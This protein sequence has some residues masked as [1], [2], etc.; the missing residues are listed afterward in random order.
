[1][2]DL[3][4]KTIKSLDLLSDSTGNKENNTR[5]KEM[6]SVA[7]LQTPK[8]AMGH[9]KQFYYCN[10]DSSEERNKFLETTIQRQLK[11]KIDILNNPMPTKINV[12]CT[13]FQIKS[14]NT[15]LQ[16]Q[17]L[18]KVRQKDDFNT[19]VHNSLGTIP[20]PQFN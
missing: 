16:S 1:M 11:K 13:L 10:P 8:I 17:L 3:K 2:L 12:Y 4:A 7:I 15:C 5:K 14:G 20:K 6:V 18:G 9:C 19:D